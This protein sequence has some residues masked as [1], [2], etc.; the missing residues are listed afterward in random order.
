MRAVMYHYVRPD[1]DRP[2]YRYYHLDLADFRRQL[3]YLETT[4]E[5]VDR[6][7]F[8]SYLGGDAEPSSDDLVL[9]FDDGLQDHHE[10]VLPELRKRDLWGLFFVSG[11]IGAS[12]L[13]VHRIHSM[14]GSADGADLA[15]ALE[16]IVEPSDVRDER[17]EAFEEAYTQYDSSESTQWFK[18]T[19]NY[20]VAYDRL[21]QLLDEIQAC[22]PGVRPVDPEEFYMDRTQLRE[23]ADAGMLLGGHTVSHPALSRLSPSAQRAEIHRSLEFVD[24]VVDPPIRSFAYPYGGTAMYDETSVEI[25]READCDLAFTTEPGEISSRAFRENPLTLNRRDCNEFV[26]GGASLD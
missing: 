6:D 5:L 15:A 2:P 9:T 24:K 10:W 22:V 1:T 17:A 16:D 25:L 19:L 18:R 23:L 11:P 7:K 8:L 13:P 21:P 4:Y 3:D 14:L 20:H 26:H 12:V